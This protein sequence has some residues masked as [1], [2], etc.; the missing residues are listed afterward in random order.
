MVDFCI[1]TV[2]YNTLMIAARRDKQN[3]DQTLNFQKKAQEWGYYAIFVFSINLT[4]FQNHKKRHLPIEY[5][6]HIWQVSPQLGCGDTCQ[7][8]MWFE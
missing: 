8:W 3:F 2:Q 5:H 4:F 1:S 7:I 6:V